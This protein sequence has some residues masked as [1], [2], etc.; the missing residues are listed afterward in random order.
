[1]MQTFKTQDNL[2]KAWLYR[3]LEAI[4]D[5]G[6]LSS[7]LYFK[8][9]TCASMLGRLDRFSVDL[10]FDFAGKVSELLK[11]RS[12][13]EEIFKNLNLKIK[14]ESK[15]GLQYFLQYENLGK[16]KTRNTIKI[17]AAF[18]LYKKSIYE[19]TR[20]EEIGRIL[21]CQNIE[22]MFAHKL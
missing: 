4:A 8:G 13:L 12:E 16:E 19:A 15:K 10:D 20:F 18:P 9:G 6:Y 11:V 3:I 7:V 21:T 22:T 17:D 1:M 2:H 14:D 5:D